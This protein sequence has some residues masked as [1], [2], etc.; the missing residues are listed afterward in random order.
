MNTAKRLKTEKSAQAKILNSVELLNLSAKSIFAEAEKLSVSNLCEINKLCQE[1]QKAVQNEFTQKLS[2]AWLELSKQVL[3]YDN[4]NEIVFLPKTDIE[5]CFSANYQNVKICGSFYGDHDIVFRF[6]KS[7]CEKVKRI[8][9]DG[10]VPLRSSDA[11]HIEDHLAKIECIEFN[12]CEI[13]D[14]FFHCCLK[15]CE[16]LESLTVK[17]C[18][19]KRAN[20]WMFEKFP[21]LTAL[22]LVQFDEVDDIMWAIFLRQSPNIK[23]LSI[24]TQWNTEKMVKCIASIAKNLDRLCINFL[25]NCDWAQ[26]ANDLKKLNHRSPLESLKISFAPAILANSP[27]R[28]ADRL[29]CTELVNEMQLHVTDC[30]DDWRSIEIFSQ[31]NTMDL[32]NV[33]N[34][35]PFEWNLS[36]ESFP[37]LNK[38]KMNG[39]N[40]YLSVKNLVLPFVRFAPKLK[41]IEIN[42]GNVGIDF[43]DATIS[44][45]NAERQKLQAAHKLVIVLK[46]SI[47][48]PIEII[49]NYATH[50]E[51]HLVKF[52]LLKS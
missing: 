16:K 49:K 12:V 37:N 14:D 51:A 27:F 21:N 40:C 29:I 32:S 42:G 7:N 30:G 3:K 26:I 52:V 43:K 45:M 25:S 48:N 50:G 44:A 20:D 19:G 35:Q 11:G 23:S 8:K 33:P 38:I 1:L 18:R 13:N 39:E 22:E 17:N 15:N 34:K 36:P 5:K 41:C 4:K 28:S 10:C 31:L 24:S 9:F 47:D 46:M 6:I 2:D